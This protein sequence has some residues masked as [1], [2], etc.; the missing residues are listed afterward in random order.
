VNGIPVALIEGQLPAIA[1][2]EHSWRRANKAMDGDARAPELFLESLGISEAEKS[3]VVELWLRGPGPVDP[4]VQM[5]IGATCGLAYKKSLG[6][7]ST[8]PI[9]APPLPQGAGRLL[10]DV[11]CNWGRW[12][13]GAERQG[14]TVLGCDAQLGA[15]AAAVRVARQ[16]GAN[17]RYLCSDA[18]FLPL[19]DSSVDV[20]L[21]YSVLQHF[22]RE[23][24]AQAVAEIGRV[25]KPGGLA[26]VQ[27][28][29][30]FGA[31][32]FYHWARRRFSPGEGFEVRY[33]TP[34]ALASLFRERIGPV[35]IVPDCYLG[36][37]LQAADR[38]L[39]T[40]IARK[41]LAASEALKRIAKSVPPLRLMADS[42]W[43]MA[44][45]AEIRA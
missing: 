13:I 5:L 40:P 20:V 43:M 45:R 31:R 16:L 42:L 26:A 17:A 19:Q 2:A 18:R 22:S 14:Y 39:M 27:M 21:S 34:R 7:L 44:T 25:L 23:D 35:R 8:Y 12:S 11:G 6:L 29:N 4:A 37:G 3:R 41:A 10:L 24:A 1:A 36:L 38:E 32:S 30:V 28:A 33:Y 9:P 15:V